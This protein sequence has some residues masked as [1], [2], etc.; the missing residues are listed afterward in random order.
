MRDKSSDYT[1]DSRGADCNGFILE[2]FEAVE[3]FEA[4]DFFFG[5]GGSGTSSCSSSPVASSTVAL[6][7]AM[8]E[9]IPPKL[10]KGP[11]IF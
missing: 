2:A 7:A 1:L 9:R 11:M 4:L 3:D 5:F 10:L 6:C 8:W